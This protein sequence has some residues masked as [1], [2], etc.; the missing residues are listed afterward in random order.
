[1]YFLVTIPLAGR[2]SEDLS[3]WLAG[4]EVDGIEELHDSLRVY[5]RSIEQAAKAGAALGGMAPVLVPDQNWS[6]SWQAEW[7]PIEIGTR[8]FLSPSWCEAETPPGRIRLEMIPGNV[9][10]GGDHPTTQLCLELLETLVVPGSRVADI[11]CGTGILTA[12]ARALGARA[13]GCDIDPAAPAD[14]TGSADALAG[15]RFDGVIAN[16]HLGV[17]QELQSELRRLLRPQGWLLVSGF[18]P[19]QSAAVEDLFGPAI[20]MREKDGWSAAVFR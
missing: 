15:A 8:F 4:L 12:A 14:F 19:D 17:L 16:I 20:Q 3:E 9:F 10:G 1:V 5:F 11:G 7:T 6:S 18:L 2:S 13:V